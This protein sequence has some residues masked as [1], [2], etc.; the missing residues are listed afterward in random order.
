MRSDVPEVNYH[1]S[2]YAKIRR[3]SRVLREIPLRRGIFASRCDGPQ[4]FNGCHPRLGEDLRC[5]QL[6]ERGESPGQGLAPGHVECLT[7]PAHGFLQFRFRGVAETETDRLG[8]WLVHEER[9]TGGDQDTLVARS[10]L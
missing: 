1:D 9:V 7:E 5:M 4:N 10:L 8:P 3:E 6:L 2:W